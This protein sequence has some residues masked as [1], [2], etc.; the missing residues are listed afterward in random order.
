MKLVAFSGSSRK[1]ENTAILRATILEALARKGMETEIVQTAGEKADLLVVN[2]N[3][4]DNLSFIGGMGRLNC[5]S[6]EAIGCSAQKP[7]L[8]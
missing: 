6:K 1:D 5:F 4:L 7:L 8:P 3:L 2:G